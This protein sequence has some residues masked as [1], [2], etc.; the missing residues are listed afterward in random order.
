VTVPVAGEYAAMRQ[1]LDRSLARMPHVALDQVQLQRLQ[2][3]D[4]RLEARLRFSIWLAS[5]APAA[6]PPGPVSA[7]V[8]R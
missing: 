3:S 5:D 6:P 4:T 1:A 7:Q 8:P 2:A